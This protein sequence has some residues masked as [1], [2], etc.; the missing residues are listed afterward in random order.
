M[1]WISLLAISRVQ[2]SLPVPLVKCWDQRQGDMMHVFLWLVKPSFCFVNLRKNYLHHS[3]YLLP[4]KDLFVINFMNLQALRL[5]LSFGSMKSY[6]TSLNSS[7]SSTSTSTSAS[8]CIFRRFGDV[9]ELSQSSSFLL[10][11]GMVVLDAAFSF[12][13]LWVRETFRAS[14]L[15]S[16]HSVWEL[17]GRVRLRVA[18]EHF[19]VIVVS[20]S[21][22]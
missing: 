8:W 11:P 17:S 1:T 13:I 21:W 2:P 14:R 19:L 18:L 10:R 4:I 3:N 22:W 9:S 16:L 6:V 7:S 20:E 5:A 15:R 12:S